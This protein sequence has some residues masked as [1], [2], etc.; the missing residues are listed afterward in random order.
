[1]VLNWSNKKLSANGIRERWLL[2]KHDLYGMFTE[3][4][5][6][7]GGVSTGHWSGWEPHKVLSYKRGDGITQGRGIIILLNSWRLFSAGR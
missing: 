4:C 5:A 6:N 3:L 1:M 7:T 2:I